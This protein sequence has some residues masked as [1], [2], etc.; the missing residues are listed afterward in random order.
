MQYMAKYNVYEKLIVADLSEAS[1]LGRTTERAWSY[2]AA[3][4]KSLEQG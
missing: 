1:I 3:L 4:L 2:M